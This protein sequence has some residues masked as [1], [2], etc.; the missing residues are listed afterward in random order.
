MRNCLAGLLDQVCPTRVSRKCEWPQDPRLLQRV[1]L[2]ECPAR[3]SPQERL[4]QECHTRVSHKCLPQECPTRVDPT[5]GSNK[6]VKQCL[7]VCF[8]VYVCA[9]RIVSSIILLSPSPCGQ[10]ENVCK[11]HPFVRPS[12]RLT[13]CSFIYPFTN[14]LVN[15][16]MQVVCSYESMPQKPCNRA[17]NAKQAFAC[18]CTC[19]VDGQTGAQR[20]TS[21]SSAT[22]G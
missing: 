8:P 11:R 1:S 18:A 9:F 15:K 12:I 14:W 16:Q 19:K 4:L 3:V 7:A 6:G 10:E 21:A 22:W 17:S 20:A 5:R 13:I 2:Q